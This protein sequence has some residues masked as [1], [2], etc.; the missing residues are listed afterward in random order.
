MTEELQSGVV[1][2]V[3]PV[4]TTATS[5]QTTNISSSPAVTW[6]QVFKPAA[7]EA[8]PAWFYSALAC[9]GQTYQ[10]ASNTQR[11]FANFLAGAD[12]DPYRQLGA[13]R[14]FVIE[15]LRNEL[16]FLTIAPS[17]DTDAA[18]G[19]ENA[20]SY[21]RT[22]AGILQM[23]KDLS[24]SAIW[25]SVTHCY[26]PGVVDLAPSL[27]DQLAQK[28]LGY[29]PATGLRRMLLGSAMVQ[30]VPT[31]DF[32]L[33]GNEQIY[34]PAPAIVPLATS[35]VYDVTTNNAIGAKIFV[36]PVAYVVDQP[37]PGQ[38]AVNRF[39]ATQVPAQGTQT[40][41]FDYGETAIFAGGPGYD[42]SK[43]AAL[44][45]AGAKPLISGSL[46]T[47]QF[48]NTTAYT[49]IPI[50]TSVVTGVSALSC[51]ALLPLAAF[52]NQRIGGFY[53]DN[54]WAKSLGYPIYDYGSA[55]SEFSIA[56]TADT[57]APETIYDPSAPFLNGGNLPN[58]LAKFAAA[59]Y[60]LSP[61]T[62]QTMIATAGEYSAP[63]AAAGL[64]VMSAAL[65]F[66]PG[67]KPSPGVSSQLTV[68]V[69]ATVTTTPRGAI[70][71]PPAV[72]QAAGQRVAVKQPGNI[73]SHVPTGPVQLPVGQSGNVLVTSPASPSHVI[74]ELDAFIPIEA[75][76]GTGITSIPIGAAFFPQSLGQGAQFEANATGTVVNLCDHGAPYALPPIDLTIG[77]LGLNLTAG[78]QYIFS[79]LETALAVR[80]SDG[81]T[82]S[83]TAAPA[84]PDPQ[85]NYVGAAVYNAGVTIV[86]LYPVLSLSLP[87]PAAGSNGIEQAQAYSVRLTYGAAQSTLDI[88]E[89][90]QIA[91]TASLAVPNPKPGDNSNPQAGDLYFGS[92][93][94]GATTLTVWAVPVFLPV[95]PAALPDASFD[96]VMVLGA[97]SSGAAA[98]ALAIT[99]S[100]LFGRLV[101]FGQCVCCRR[102]DQFHAR[103]RFRHCLRPGT[104]CSR[105]DSPGKDWRKPEICLRA[106]NR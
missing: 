44:T 37:T 101:Q 102:C 5:A 31:S 93:L 33:A 89:S 24:N 52:T 59:T 15:F 83:V 26:V 64:S 25:P 18:L 86:Q 80:G 94:G 105:P 92:F 68:P 88:F 99:D 6:G 23:Y 13:T 11:G 28:V 103:R 62:L 47:T 7:L 65:T 98:Y 35:L 76:L 90:N 75:L 66:D 78:V 36:L 1:K 29:D 104:I 39:G 58:V 106:R 10:D 74:V 48:Q 16:F 77:G 71:Q 17:V 45:L 27:E 72:A 40:P 32:A 87:A 73:I 4:D 22:D 49:S 56:N 2:I 19:L 38:F 96:G 55:N 91:I 41:P 42:A 95:A 97:V 85:H 79:L 51:S 63:G 57:I 8:A 53:R 67:A 54:T 81:S 12:V 100:S 30:V 21:Q 82:Q 61:D 43:A 84:N 20:Q 69:T 60:I 50:G 46:I 3:V 70:A 9:L 14:L 34:N